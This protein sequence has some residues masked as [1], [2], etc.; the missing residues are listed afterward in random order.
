MR[1]YYS[2]IKIL[3]YRLRHSQNNTQATLIPGRYLG[4]KTRSC[5]GMRICSFFISFYTYHVSISRGW[6]PGTTHQVCSCHMTGLRRLLRGTLGRRW[7]QDGGEVEPHRLAWEKR[8]VC[9]YIHTRTLARMHARTHARTHVL[10]VVVSLVVI[11]V[12]F[13]RKNIRSQWFPLPLH[14]YEPTPR[15]RRVQ[16]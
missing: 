16:W 2:K 9:T 11:S 6:L 15:S 3:I 8:R 10:N 14:R 4:I 12:P 1:F 13:S 7:V 5:F